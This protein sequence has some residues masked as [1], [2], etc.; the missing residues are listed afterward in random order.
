MTNKKSKK[1]EL[2][3]ELVSRIENRL[4]YS[5]FETVEEYVNFSMNQLLYEVEQQE[6]ESQ[7]TTDNAIKDRL[8]SLGYLDK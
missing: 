5:E 4:E 3:P 8:Q 2:Q 7:A 6:E 1:I